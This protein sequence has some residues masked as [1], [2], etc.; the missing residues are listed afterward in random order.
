MSTESP[1][2]SNGRPGSNDA[3]VGQGHQLSLPGGMPPIGADIRSPF[4]PSAQEP[5]RVPS[6]EQTYA[7]NGSTSN[8]TDQPFPELGRAGSVLSWM[9]EWVAPRS[10]ANPEAPAG[11][12]LFSLCSL[13]EP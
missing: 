10:R 12:N 3:F 1:W 5:N 6:T 13:T 8:P 9:L 11:G 7:R 2:G 4:A